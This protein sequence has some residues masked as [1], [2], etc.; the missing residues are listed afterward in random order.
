[1]RAQALLNKGELMKEIRLEAVLVAVGFAAAVIW[2]PGAV[3]DTKNWW[4][5]KTRAWALD[6]LQGG[7]VY[8]ELPVT[9]KG[10]KVAAKEMNEN[11]LREALAICVA[12]KDS[13]TWDLSDVEDIA[14]RRIKDG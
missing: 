10:V 5:S 8:R 11:D 6:V 9:V 4:D 1:M 3:R 13:L 2:G 14:K 7:M 12:Q